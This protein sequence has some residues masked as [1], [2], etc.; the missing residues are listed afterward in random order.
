MP[1]PAVKR[2]LFGLTPSPQAAAF[3]SRTSGLDTKHRNAYIKLI[4]GLVTDGLWDKIDALWILATADATTAGLNLKNTSFTL[5]L[6]NS[7]TFT[8]DQGYTGNG[9]NQTISTGFAPASS[10]TAFSQNSASI[11]AYVRNSRTS[12]NSSNIMGCAPASGSTA[13]FMAPLQTS[14]F[15]W[16]LNGTTFP[17]SANTDAQGFWTIS[18]TA[19]NNQPAYKNGLP[20]ASNSGASGVLTNMTNA[21]RLLSNSTSGGVGASFSSDQ[22]SAAHIGGAFNDVDV[23]NYSTRVNAFMTSIGANIY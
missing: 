20:F 6:T 16:T 14:A 21:V 8:V 19:S 3:L 15:G 1:S 23:F 5:S 10:G 7:P 12:S 2:I 4:N 22:L 9:T 13:F 11:S 18:R 17:S